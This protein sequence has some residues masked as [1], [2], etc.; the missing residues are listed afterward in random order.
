[1]RG[2]ALTY[3]RA[4]SLALLAIASSVVSAQ[5]TNVKTPF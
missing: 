1:M 3:H 5:W 2:A 4:A